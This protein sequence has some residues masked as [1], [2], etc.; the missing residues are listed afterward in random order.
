MPGGP[1][2]R[3]ELIA[4][5]RNTE[6]F[7]NRATTAAMVAVIVGGCIVVWDWWGWDRT[8]VSGAEGFGL[9]AFGLVV[10]MQLVATAGMIPATIAPGIASERDKKTLDALLATRLTS[11]EVILGALAAGLVKFAIGLLAVVPVLVLVVYLGGIDPRLV[12]LAYAGIISTAF[13]LA[14]LSIASS[15]GARSTK[16]AIAGTLFWM[17]P[18]IMPVPTAILLP[19]FWPAAAAWLVP[20]LL[21][22]LD[23]SPFAVALNLLGAIRRTT[24]IG[25]VLRMIALQTSAAVVLILWAIWRL[26]PASRAVYDGEGRASLLRSLRTRRRKRPPCYDDPVLWNEIHSM[27]DMKAIDRISG[28]IIGLVAIGFIIYLTSW[29]AIPAFAEVAERG[30]GPAPT[31]TSLIMPGYLHPFVR[32]LVNKLSPGSGLPPATPGEARLEFNIVLREVT[33][34]VAWLYVMMV[35]SAAAEGVAAEKER[36]TW[37]G[38]IATPL[39]GAEIL[40]AKMI[41]AVWKCRGLTVPLI[42]VWIVALL[43]GALHPLG[44]LLAL[45][46]LGTTSWFFAALGMRASLWAKNRKRAVE[47]VMLP[48]MVLPSI[49]Y[50]VPF[51]PPWSAS[52]LMGFA[53]LPTLL[54]ASLI[55][56]DDV[57]AALGQGTFPQL[58]LVHINTG[59]GA[60][61]VLAAVLL[62]LTVHTVGAALLTRASARRFD[63]AVGRPMRREGEAAVSG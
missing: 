53:S 62:G 20:A 6:L 15:A 45:L 34:A 41:G 32:T 44:F 38:L 26:R 24:P 23:S 11:A 40:R 29:F 55:S 48:S 56:Y 61:K 16:R 3:R 8:S 37:L 2:L 9:T 42:A 60:W 49:G 19:R 59:E 7:S 25:S 22:V 39:S 57:A 21:W 12:A 52:V 50:V 63:E 30:Y 1:I 33:A 46:V 18:W 51:L 31:S 28:Q 5:Q 14:A 47:R 27:R 35:A 10:V 36:D 17:I 43:A 4:A 58:A 13:V 54:W